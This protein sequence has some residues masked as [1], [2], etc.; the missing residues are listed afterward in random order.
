MDRRAALLGSVVACLLVTGIVVAEL[1]T[2]V[3]AAAL[4]GPLLAGVVSEPARFDGALEGAVAAGAAVP[5]G[6]LGVAVARFLTF[7]G[8]DSPLRLLW[9]TGGPQ[10]IGA[11]FIV[12]PLALV[13][14]AL[15]GWLGQL[16][17]DLATS[18]VSV[19]GS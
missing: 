12:L 3:T 1:P 8:A 13:A 18:G 19:A 4:A 9:L 6:T 7:Q 17:R 2:P 15:V 14:G 11:V 10:A 5:L 16:V